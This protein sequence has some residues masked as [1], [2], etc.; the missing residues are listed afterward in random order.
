[1]DGGYHYHS[2]LRRHN[3]KN[4]SAKTIIPNNILYLLFMPKSKKKST[5]IDLKWILTAIVIMLLSGG[6]LLGLLLFAPN[7]TKTG[8]VYIKPG[9]SKNYTFAYLTDSGFLSLPFTTNIAA[10]LIHVPAHIKPGK[11]ALTAGE[12]NFELLRMLRNGK[13][14]SIKIT[15]NKMRTMNELEHLLTSNLNVTAEQL[16]NQLHKSKYLNHYGIDSATVFCGIMPDTYEYFWCA[17]AETIFSKIFKNYTHFWTDARKEKATQLGLTPQTAT[18][19]ASIVEEETNKAEDKPLIACVYLNRLAKG[20][21]LQADPTVK[22]AIGDFT[23]KRVT[24][25]M[26]LIPSPYNTYQNTGLPPSCICTPMPATIDAVLSAPKCSYIYFCANA[27]LDGSTS[28]ASTDEQHLK[29]ARAYQQ[30]LNQRG[31]H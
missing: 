15:I 24:G 23:I 18:I 21:K 2:L 12:S 6:V 26:L 27:S 3:A 7:V 19:L 9:E 10:S 31:I 5:K 22:Y 4:L 14:V 30:A 16:E 8:F 29:N 17:S 1:M 25:N 20:M 13:Q 28:F 11:Y